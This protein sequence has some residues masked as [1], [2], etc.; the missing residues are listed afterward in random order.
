MVGIPLTIFFIILV[1]FQTKGLIAKKRWK[2][3]A[4]YLILFSFGAVYSYGLLLDLP[5]PN[6]NLTLYNYLAPIYQFIFEELLAFYILV[7]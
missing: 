3:L 7:I 4:L 2:E 1:Y 5:L 6:L